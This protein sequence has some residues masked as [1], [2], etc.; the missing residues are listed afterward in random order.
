M[1]GTMVASSFI[2]NIIVVLAGTGT[3]TGTLYFTNL[4]VTS[5]VNNTS[6]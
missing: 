1:Y 2:K 5:S 6:Y 3:G 4:L